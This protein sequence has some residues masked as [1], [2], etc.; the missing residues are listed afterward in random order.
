[1]KKYFAMF[2]ILLTFSLFPKNV[3]FV[4]IDKDL[5]IPLEGVKLIIANLD[6]TL[7]TDYDGKSELFI[8]ENVTK[9]SVVAMLIGYETKKVVI[10]DF[11]KP[12][13]IKML[14]QGVLEGKELVIEEKSIGKKDEK[15]GVS[16][17]I[18]KQIIDSSAKIGP[19]EDIMS[20]IK[21]LPGVG[22][23]GKFDSRP[24]VRGGHPNE[25]AATLDGFLVRFPYH[26]GGAVSIF[27][28]NLIDSVKFSNGIVPT[29]FGFVQSGL[30]EIN[31]KKP[32]NGLHLDLIIATTT[33]ELFFQAPLWKNSGIL[34]SGR[35]TYL[36]LTL[37]ILEAASVSISENLRFNTK[38]YIRDGSLKWFWKPTDRVEWYINFFTGN[39]GAGLGF[40]QKKEF[41]KIANS[42]D[43]DNFKF[44]L[45][46]TTGFK[47]LPTDKMQLEFLAGYEYYQTGYTGEQ[48]EQGE[49]KYSTDFLNEYNTKWKIVNPLLP[50]L[51]N[52][53]VFHANFI[54]NIESK[55]IMHSFQTR[56]DSDIVINDKITFSY[57]GG[58][59]FDFYSNIQNGK[60]W[61][62]QKMPTGLD[63]VQ[64]DFKI[65]AEDNNI[66][67]S[68]L[69]FN[70]NFIPVPNILTIDTGLRVDHF[71]IVGKEFTLNTYPVPL[72]RFLLNWTAVRNQKY[73]NNFTISI[74][75]GLFSKVPPES[76]SVDK[77]FKLKDF[78]L[79]VPLNLTTI[80]GTE[81]EFPLGF[82]LKFEGYYKYYFNK[83]YV[84][85]DRISGKIAEE[86]RDG[87]TVRGIFSNGE[88]HTAG[89]DILIQRNI[90]RYV[91]GWLSYS[92]IFA[93]YKN[94]DALGPTPNTTLR[95]EPTKIWYYPSFQRYHNFNLILNI[96]PTNFCTIMNKFTF[97]SGRPRDEYGER[98]SFFA[99]SRANGELIE[100]YGRDTI[101]TDA[102]KDGIL[103][104]TKLRTGFSFVYDLKVA[105]NFYIPDSK[106]RFEIY[107][108]GE[109]L[110]VML[111]NYLV[112]GKIIPN[113]NGMSL[114]K[115]TGEEIPATDANFRINFPIPSVGIKISF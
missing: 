35:V 31:S 64:T 27:N 15:A 47:I 55:N 8:D 101:Y 45:F 6:K 113:E 89:F 68:S 53:S 17:V 73:L 104:D 26:W 33:S 76:T 56:F 51:T 18:D 11:S 25:V 114:D 71:F 97:A 50:N 100:M 58:F 66:F 80:L 95:N 70:F 106:V 59:I 82:K 20:S 62:I 3:N 36:D 4:V 49:K 44:D 30:I 28:P 98:K 74:G 32:D 22:Y 87:K 77:D 38:P 5:D 24:S 107:V 79:S 69:Y 65:N 2:F 19:V 41:G 43:F 92:F 13:V 88:G 60:I 110:F 108:A 67:L 93:I 96:K 94:P 9:L 102:Y 81:F 75:A 37:N 83:F 85:P 42:F 112:D 10:N 72:P 29:K 61:T 1:M 23:G 14:I 46:T 7:F 105:F 21:T 34:I 84:V 52:D 111:F 40:A 57:G 16:T 48:R 90:S 86:E 39:D 78:E 103:N 91:D 109:D 63:Y 99:T 12:I 115:Y 54:N